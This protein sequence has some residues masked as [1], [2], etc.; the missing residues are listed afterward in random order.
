[1]QPES[2]RSTYLFAAGLPIQFRMHWLFWL[3]ANLFLVFGSLILSFISAGCGQRPV[4]PS[5]PEKGFRRMTVTVAC[6]GEPAASVVHRYGQIWGAQTGARVKVVSYDVASGPESGTSAD[7]WVVSPAR[8]PHWADAGKLQPLP[9]DL[10]QRDAAYAWQNVLPL[11]RYKLCVWDQKVYALP[12][13]GDAL[14]C[15]YRQDLFQDPRHRDAFRSKYGRELA[16]PVTWE[17]FTDI[18]EYFDKAKRPGVDR[19]CPSLPP[20]PESLDDLDRIFYSVAAPSVRR[21]VRED[22]PHPPGNVELFS[23]HYDVESGAVRIDT[24][25][26]IS[27]LQ[28]LKRLQVFRPQG[29]ARDAL[30]AFQNGEAILC[31]ATPA[32]IGRFQERAAVRDRFSFCRVPGSGHV[33]AYATG[34]EQFLPAGNWVPYLGADGWMMVVPRSNPAP[35]AAFA[36]AAF[37][38]SPKISQDIVIEPAWGGGVYRREHLEGGIGWQQLGLDRK[39]SERLVDVLRETVLHPPVKNPVLRLRTPDEREHQQALDMELRAALLDGKDAGR[40]LHAA[41]ARWREID[42]RKDLKARL[43]EYRVSL[44]LHR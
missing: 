31:L 30:A 40:A 10:L 22:D 41:A 39:L 42:E 7:L 5:P 44:S 4:A 14:L 32:W 21:G 2:S 28:L 35:E 37:L 33:F 12:L 34:Q 43:A 20:L 23:F 38:S 29:V 11:Y 24:P 1:M 15:F 3:Q 36:L 13:L 6:P 27:A 18:A 25:G 19:P 8:M 9:R 17:Q 16:A 26:F